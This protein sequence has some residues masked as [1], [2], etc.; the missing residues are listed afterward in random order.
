MDPVN[1]CAD[2][3]R[4]Y[5]RARELGGTG[6]L[7]AARVSPDR[8]AQSTARSSSGHRARSDRVPLRYWQ[9]R[10][11]TGWAASGR[12]GGAGVLRRA[13]DVEWGTTVL[14]GAVSGS[15]RGARGG[16]AG[17]RALREADQALATRADAIGVHQA[18]IACRVGHGR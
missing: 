9:Q 5:V 7:A 18:R 6:P 16:R 17:R 13:A 1:T 8:V 3:D 10:R 14:C 2:V 11:T 4:L 12:R 15:V